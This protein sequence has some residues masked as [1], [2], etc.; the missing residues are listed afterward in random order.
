MILLMQLKASRQ[1]PTEQKKGRLTRILILSNHYPPHY[2]GGYG[3]RCQSVTEELARRGYEIQVLTSDWHTGARPTRRVE[4]SGGVLTHR[5]LHIRQPISPHPLRRRGQHLRWA[6]AAR[7]D[8]RTAYNLMRSLAPDL[9][10]VWSMSHLALSPLAAAQDL[11]L[12]LVFDL[13]DYWLLQRYQ[14]LQAEPD[15]RRRRYRLWIHGLSSFDLSCFPHILVNSRTLKHQY[16]QA[17]FPAAQLTVIPRGLP[18]A[19]IR[20]T[21]PPLPPRP[22]LQLLYVGRLT[23]AKGAHLAIEAVALLNGE[24]AAD[25][26]R[27]AHLDLVGTGEADYQERLRR[28]VAD[29]GLARVVRFLGRLPQQDLMARYGGYDALLLPSVW[30]EPFGGAALEAMAQGTCVIASDRGGP[31]ELIRHGQTGLLVP[32]E[33]P[34]ALAQAVLSLAHDPARRDRI[35]RAAIAAVRAAYTLEQV[36]DRVEAYLQSAWSAKREPA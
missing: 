19:W 8:Y 20:E 23:E 16:T 4:T 33:D 17:G 28:Q 12:P 31:A 10:Y 25:L 3:L 1:A 36:G 13:G 18:A 32:P 15:A 6:V 35:R 14:E 11:N 21:P 24:R 2:K 29:R 22:H 5:L 34:A 26:G 27:P 7:R 30:V 9:V